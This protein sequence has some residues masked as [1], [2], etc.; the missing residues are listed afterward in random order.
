MTDESQELAQELMTITG[1]A[2]KTIRALR[3]MFD[4][5]TMPSMDELID[6]NALHQHLQAVG[7]QAYAE[8]YTETEMRDA[9]VFL[10]SPSG[11]A[12]KSKEPVVEQRITAALQAHLAS[13][14]KKGS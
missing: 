12:M 2:D 1:A 6:V 3:G 7:A 13:A 11:Q 5:D 4:G 10:R 9:L 14:V 8:V